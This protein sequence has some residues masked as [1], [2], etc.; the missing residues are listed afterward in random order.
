MRLVT[1][2]LEDKDFSG[3]VEQRDGRTVRTNSVNVAHYVQ[4]TCTLGS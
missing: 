2:H 4:V 1:I 3:I